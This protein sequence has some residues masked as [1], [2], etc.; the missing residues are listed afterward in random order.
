MLFWNRVELYKGKS[1]KEFSEL[2]NALATAGIRYDY[3][4]SKYNHS[5]RNLQDSNNRSNLTSE[6]G[7]YLEYRLYVHHK[8]YEEAMF[9]TSNRNKS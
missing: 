8:D 7:S 6:P 9:L 3:K 4:L 1:L 5:Y 2:K